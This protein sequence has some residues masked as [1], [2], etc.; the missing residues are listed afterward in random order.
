MPPVRQKRCRA[1]VRDVALV[2]CRERDNIAARAGEA[3]MGIELLLIAAVVYVAIWLTVL[4]G[5]RFFGPR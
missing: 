5:S 2:K 3:G 4:V 1:L